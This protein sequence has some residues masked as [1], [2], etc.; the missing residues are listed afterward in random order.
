MNFKMLKQSLELITFMVNVHCIS[1][2]NSLQK[3]TDF[4]IFLYNMQLALLIWSVSKYEVLFSHFIFSVCIELVS[5]VWFL[6]KRI[7]S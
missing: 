6:R 7:S 1:T 5:L 2:I 3:D 4:M